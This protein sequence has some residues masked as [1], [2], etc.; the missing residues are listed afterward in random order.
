M[1]NP[2]ATRPETA[3]LLL[4]IATVA[5]AAF[6]IFFRLGHY[7]LWDDEAMDALNARAIVETGDVSAVLGHNIVAYRDGLLLVNLRHQ[8]M[9]PLPGFA[10][11]LS[12]LSFGESAFAARLPFALAGL[13]CVAL[14]MAWGC[15][16]K[17]GWV[18]VLLLSLAILGNVSLLLY[19]RNGHYYALGI[20]FNVA[21]AYLYLNHLDRP[22]SQLIIALV[23]G[24]FMTANYS[25]YVTFAACAGLDFLV[26]RRREVRL[27]VADYARLL[28]PQVPFGL[29]L[30]WKFNPLGT[31]LGGYLGENSL[32]DRLQLFLWNWR[33]LNACEFI[34]G[35]LLLAILGAWRFVGSPLLLRALVCLF[36]YVTSVT[37]LS[38]QLI[39][40][41]SVADVRYLAGAIPLCIAIAV[42]ALTKVADRS[43]VAALLI[44]AIAFGTNLLNGGPLAYDG[45]RSTILAYLGELRSPV[46][47]PYTPVSEW[48]TRHVPQ[49]SSVWVVPDYMVYPL[50]F[51]AP[52]PTYAWQLSSENDDP[53]FAKLESIHF[54]G[55]VAPDF[56]IVFGP[57]IAQIAP[58][59]EQFAQ[60]GVTYAHL[61]TLPVY[62]RD[63]YRPELFWRTFRT[64]GPTDPVF[65]GVQIFRRV[66]PQR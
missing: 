53:Q 18:S 61:A 16:A 54:Q 6:L 56:I 50:L 9:P 40:Q 17:R 38:T 57:A 20:L 27:G 21:L 60:K 52:H 14:M 25:W 5:L 32:W 10:M 12:F 2:A 26:W 64:V 4:A 33:D 34:P 48:I 39:H 8:A 42:M 13:A 29:F 65:D 46:A 35:L 11:A 24:L 63:L 30:L 36:V 19:F 7:S 62:W 49:R 59:L 41:T 31:K 66:P 28:L 58:L 37:L 47:E 51:N 15:M 23:G 45:F 1:T 43:K 55:R 44:G 22:V 3:S